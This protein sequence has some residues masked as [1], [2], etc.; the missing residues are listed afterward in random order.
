MFFL[1]QALLEQMC[2]GARIINS[3]S[4][5]SYFGVPSHLDYVT[6][7]GAGCLYEVIVQ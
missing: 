4:V 3:A 6:T 7:K 1:T 2:S 5:D